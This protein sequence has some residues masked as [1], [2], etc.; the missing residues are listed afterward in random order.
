MCGDDEARVGVGR[1]APTRVT[2]R[3]SITRSSRV[4]IAGGSSPTSSRKSVPPEAASN[5]PVARVCAPVK[6]PFSWPKRIDS[7]SVSVIAP[8][9]CATK[10]PALREP[11]SWIARASSSLPTPVLPT[12]STGSSLLAARRTSSRTRSIALA[13]GVEARASATLGKSTMKRRGPTR[14]TAPCPTSRGA[15][16]FC[17]STSVPRRL[18]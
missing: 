11:P 2:S 13:R 1:V 5:T 10:G 18:S 12:S 15:V 3:C 6:A 9:F 17:P 14:S 7:A 16:S 4:C 8:Q